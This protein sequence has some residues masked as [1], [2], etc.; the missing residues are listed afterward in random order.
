MAASREPL[1]RANLTKRDETDTC[2]RS[3]SAALTERSPVAQYV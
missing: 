1:M 3:P 2:S